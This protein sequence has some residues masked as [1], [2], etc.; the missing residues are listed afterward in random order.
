MS[1]NMEVILKILFRPPKQTRVNDTIYLSLE[2]WA[3]LLSDRLK[4]GHDCI[5]R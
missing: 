2:V 5:I 1:E 4:K 3:V